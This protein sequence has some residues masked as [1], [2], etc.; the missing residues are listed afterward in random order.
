M[1]YATLC[2]C[3]HSVI[4]FCV[5]TMNASSGV[6]VSGQVGRQ[7]KGV[8]IYLEP[9]S[10]SSASEPSGNVI[11]APSAS[12]VPAP[13]ADELFAKVGQEW[14]CH[15]S[16]TAV[17]F[18]EFKQHMRNVRTSLFSN[19]HSPQWS[20]AAS[21]RMQEW[22]LSIKR[23]RFTVA[24]QLAQALLPAPPPM[25]DQ[26]AGPEAPPPVDE[27]VPAPVNYEAL[28]EDVSAELQELQTDHDA[29]KEELYV[30]NGQLEE[31]FDRIAVLEGI[32]VD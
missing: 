24:P 26:P 17:S 15:P 22:L 14:L 20:E 25:Y 5:G 19:P 27:G 11:F 9:T 2:V 1:S 23:P 30:V 10:V 32:D 31:A 13:T 7:G 18:N 21:L 16:R 8:A 28:Y 6:R 29:L 4:S 12:C 3:A